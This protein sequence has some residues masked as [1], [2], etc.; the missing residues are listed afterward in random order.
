MVIHHTHIYNICTTIV[1]YVIH[2]KYGHSANLCG[3]MSDNCHGVGTW[4]NCGENMH[5]YVNNIY[6][7]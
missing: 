7:Y 6:N 4:I 2:C 3:V 1:L 5:R